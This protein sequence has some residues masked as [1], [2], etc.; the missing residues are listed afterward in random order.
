MHFRTVPIPV[1]RNRRQSQ[2][3]DSNHIGDLHAYVNP[4]TRFGLGG[5]T[6]EQ[7]IRLARRLLSIGVDRP[8]VAVGVFSRLKAP[9]P[10]ALHQLRKVT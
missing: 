10:I 5:E 9:A 7:R 3:Q 1:T 6:S 2:R 8:Q 4:C